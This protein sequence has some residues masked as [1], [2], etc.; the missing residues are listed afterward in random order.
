MKC[1]ECSECKDDDDEDAAT[2]GEWIASVQVWEGGGG[3]REAAVNPR[4][5]HLGHRP[6][7]VLHVDRP[8]SVLVPRELPDSAHGRRATHFSDI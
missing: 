5:S 1:L 6:Q 8:Q 2:A 4:L 7:H 3:C